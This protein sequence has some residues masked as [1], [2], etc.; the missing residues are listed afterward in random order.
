[1]GGAGEQRAVLAAAAA[2]LRTVIASAVPE[3]RPGL[4]TTALLEVLAEQGP[5]LPLAEIEAVL[6]ELDATRFAPS[7]V[8]D[9]AEVA[10]RAAALAERIAEVPA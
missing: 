7:A 10:R 3:A 5:A 1:M 4:D 9:A 6:R 2:V 8:G